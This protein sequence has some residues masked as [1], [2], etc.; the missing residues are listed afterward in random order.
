MRLSN[1]VIH[2]GQLLDDEGRHALERDLGHSA[3]V[4]DAY[5]HESA[6]HL[7]VVNFDPTE[8]GAAAI[9]HC[10]RHRGLRAEM[11]SCRVRT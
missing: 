3:G 11:V 2:L 5:V 9:V 8:V 10:V 1:I 4:Y 7:V 6:R